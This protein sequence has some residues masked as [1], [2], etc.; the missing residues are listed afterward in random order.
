MPYYR[1][2][3]KRITKKTIILY[4]GIILVC[5]LLGGAIS[6]LSTRVSTFVQQDTKSTPP[7]EAERFLWMQPDSAYLQEIEKTYSLKFDNPLHKLEKRNSE[8]EKTTG[9]FE[10]A[11]DN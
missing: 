9:A 10:Q 3:R 11:G 4:S 1:K 7:I 8:A 2:R 6:F 5:F